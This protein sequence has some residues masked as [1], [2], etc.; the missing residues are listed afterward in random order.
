MV[1][2]RPS[3]SSIDRARDEGARLVDDPHQRQLRPRTAVLID[4]EF[5]NAHP[6]AVVAPCA[7]RAVPAP[8]LVDPRVGV[9]VAEPTALRR[10][11]A[12]VF[13]NVGVSVHD[14]VDAQMVV[15]GVGP[16]FVDDL[17]FMADLVGDDARQALEK[18]GAGLE[19]RK[20]RLR[21]RCFD[22]LQAV[23]DRVGG[24]LVVFATKRVELVDQFRKLRPPAD[25]RPFSERSRPPRRILRGL[26]AERF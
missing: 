15:Q 25:G 3:G 22:L 11:V 17:L 2:G 19:R 9:D 21:G 18:C 23:R 16:A 8:A 12:L 26:P 6:S 10:E 4:A 5:D 14:V 20:E 13:R 1:L 24:Q 7:A